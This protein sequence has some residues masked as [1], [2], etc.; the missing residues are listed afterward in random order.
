LTAIGANKSIPG[1]DNED[2]S[3]SGK[4]LIIASR[5]IIGYNKH[6]TIIEIA[7]TSTNKEFIESSDFAQ[8]KELLEY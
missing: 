5:Q 6:E 4:Y 8:I 2:T 3:L 7:T 1:E